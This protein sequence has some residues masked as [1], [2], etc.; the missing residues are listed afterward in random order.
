MEDS[1]SVATTADTKHD[2]RW[3]V[4]KDGTPKLGLTLALAGAKSLALAPLH[5][6]EMPWVRAWREFTRSMR[7]NLACL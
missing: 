4:S 3:G 5:Q 2:L 7:Y 6:G 1:G